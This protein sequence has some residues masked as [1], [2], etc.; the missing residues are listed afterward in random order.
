MPLQKEHL[1]KNFGKSEILIL[2]RKRMKTGSSSKTASHLRMNGS[3]AGRPLPAEAWGVEK[4]RIAVGEPH[5]RDW[6]YELLASTDLLYAMEDSKLNLINNDYR[7]EIIKAFQLKAEYDEGFFILTIPIDRVLF[8][9]H[10]GRLHSHLGLKITVYKDHKKIDTVEERKTCSF[11]ES[12]G[13]NMN[14]IAVKILYQATKKGYYLFD[15]I[16]T[17]LNS[18]YESKYRAVI[19]KTLAAKKSSLQLYKP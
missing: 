18:L 9:E 11:S 10:E 17:D 19:K 4:K 5:L 6:D 8:K 13:L 16:I 14:E 2:P 7:G 3:E 1:S 15:L 12:E